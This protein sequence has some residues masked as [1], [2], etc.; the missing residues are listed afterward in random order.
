MVETVQIGLKFNPSGPVNLGS[1]LHH[2]SSVSFLDPFCFKYTPKIDPPLF[3]G[4][5]PRGFRVRKCRKY[6]QIYQIPGEQE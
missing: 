2:V 3:D 4:E 5:N 6:L 1:P